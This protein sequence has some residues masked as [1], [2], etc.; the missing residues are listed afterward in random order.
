LAINQHLAGSGFDA[1]TVRIMVDAYEAVRGTLNLPSGDNPI[2]SKIADKVIQLARDGE[3][4]PDVISKR[5]LLW[6]GRQ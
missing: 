3:R 4:N 2:N 5:V 6:M 1:D